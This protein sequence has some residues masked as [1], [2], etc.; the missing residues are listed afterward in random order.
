MLLPVLLALLQAQAPRAV[1]LTFDDL[2]GPGHVR[3]DTAQAFDLNRRLIHAL[4]FA[5]APA[6]VF[7]T[8]GN[9]C[10]RLRPAALGPLVALWERSG[11]VVGNHGHRHLDLSRVPL[12]EY[13]ADLGLADSLLR[14]E[15]HLVPRYFRHN[16]LHAGRDSATAAGLDRWLTRRGY[17]VAPVT[18]DNH[19]WIYAGAYQRALAR[20]D[21]AMLARLVPAYLVHLEQA[22]AFAESLSVRVVGEEIPQVLLLHA[23][24]LNRDHLGAVL[25]LAQRRGYRFVSLEE[26]LSHPAYRRRSHYVG[27][28]GISWLLRWSP[29]PAVWQLE[30]PPVPPWVRR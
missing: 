4:D 24:D 14:H 13:L 16:F 1:A 15:G 17:A 9:F 30:L 22:F 26:A 3:C 23:N 10:D 20:G 19:E 18:I 2:P 8:T 12:A 21:S 27:S 28:L 25:R 29:D 11:A 6:A 5:R 7:V